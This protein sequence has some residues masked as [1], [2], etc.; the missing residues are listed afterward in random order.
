MNNK[1]F[2]V[3]VCASGGGGNFEAVIKG[4]EVFGYKVNLLIVD[5]ECGAINKAE[6]NDIPYVQLDKKELGENFFRVMDQS[7]PPDTDL[8][9]LAGFFPILDGFFCKKWSGQII[10]THPSLLPKYGGKGMYGVKVQEAVLANKDT[11]AGCTVHYVNEGIDEG[12]IVLQKT[13]KVEGNE[14][15][16]ELGRKVFLEENKLLVE[17]IGVIMNKQKNRTP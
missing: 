12:E 16:W 17:A 13:V 6:Q 14:S 1:Q 2:N 9:V 7:I 11:L 5:R 15:A 10:N 8:V 3:T 4:Q